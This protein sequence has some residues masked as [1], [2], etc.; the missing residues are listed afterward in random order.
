MFARQPCCRIPGLP[1]LRPVALRP[2]LS[3]GLPLSGCVFL[4]SYIEAISS[5]SSVVPTV[6]DQIDGICAPRLRESKVAAS[7][8]RTLSI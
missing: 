3:G 6:P 8:R 1:G 2:T 7:E 4:C 5:P